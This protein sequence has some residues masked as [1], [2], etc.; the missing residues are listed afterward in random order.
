MKK[1]ELMSHIV[2]FLAF[3]SVTVLIFGASCMAMPSVPHFAPEPPVE[4]TDTTDKSTGTVHDFPD[5]ASR[6]FDILGLVWATSVSQY[7]D[8]KIVSS[9]EGIIL[10]LLKEAENLGGNDILNL[11]TDES[12]VEAERR[13]RIEGRE[14]TITTRTVTQTGSALAIRYRN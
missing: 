13:V 5:P 1:N 6:P 7:E 14:R 8:G 10:M 12:V 9:Q 4:K 11:R 3:V 2:F